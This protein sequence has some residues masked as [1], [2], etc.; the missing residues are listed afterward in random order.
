MVK[1]LFKIC[2]LLSIGMNLTGQEIELNERTREILKEFAFSDNVYSY[3]LSS[4]ELYN[5][6]ERKEISESDFKK[7]RLIEMKKYGLDKTNQQQNQ[8][9]LNQINLL[10]TEAAETTIS[11]NPNNENN[12]V[13]STILFFNPSLGQ[14]NTPVFY[15]NDAGITWNQSNFDPLAATTATISNPFFIYGTSDPTLTIDNDGIIHFVY[16]MMYEA[17]AGNIQIGTYYVYSIDGGQ[18]FIIPAAS[19]FEIT[20]GGIGWLNP[21]VFDRIWVT[22]DNSEGPHDG[23]LYLSGQFFS[24]SLISES[25][26]IYVKYPQANGFNT[27]PFLVE[28]TAGQGNNIIVDQN[29]IIHHASITINDNSGF[30]CNIVYNRS[31]DQGQ[32]WQTPSVIDSSVVLT[33]NLNFLIHERENC[34]PSLATSNNHLFLAWTD[35]EDSK[36]RSYITYSSDGGNTWPWTKELGPIFLNGPYFHLMPCL[37]SYGNKCSVSWFVVDSLTLQAEYHIGEIDYNGLST[38]PSIVVSNNPTIFSTNEF[39]G[40]YNDIDRDSCFVYAIWAEGQSVTP[41]TPSTYV[42]K[43]DLCDNVDLVEHTPLSGKISIMILH[44]NPVKNELSLQFSTK[45]QSNFYIVISDGLGKTV[46]Q[47]S[48]GNIYKGTHKKSINLSELTPGYYL[49]SL[50][51]ENGLFISKKFIKN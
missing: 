43:V 30:D 39:Y 48:L 11:I 41:S 10:E 9:K 5:R 15:S 20:T 7:L 1:K 31:L 34:A 19:D 42:V 4:I 51:S 26:S 38:G 49:L 6:K 2:F 17:Q 18:N 23:T 13:A 21:P 28:D 8:L 3:M 25:K 32:T 44:P 47:H 14:A 16:L 46:Q 29:G 37:A 27:T 22:A 50:I 12:I 24:S 36:V 35:F 45:F 40:D 33:S